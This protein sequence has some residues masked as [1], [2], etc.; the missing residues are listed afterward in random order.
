MNNANGNPHPLNEALSYFQQLINAAIKGGLFSNAKAV[1]QAQ[2]A[3]SLLH[4]EINKL[5]TELTKIQEEHLRTKQPT[6][7]E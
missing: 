6:K 5:Q 3:L 1:E 7:T 4:G 2:A